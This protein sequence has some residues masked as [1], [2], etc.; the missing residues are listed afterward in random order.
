MRGPLTA[1]AGLTGKLTAHQRRAVSAGLMVAVAVL[2]WL[3]L[4][5]RDW[6]PLFPLGV[7]G[8]A[9]AL[10]GHRLRD[11]LWLGALCGV[12]HYVVALRW[13]TD[14]SPPGY[15]AVAV[16]ETVLLTAVAAVSPGRS[17]GRWP[18][19]WLVAPAAL[20]L[21]EAVQY[22]FPFGGFP[23]PALGLSLTDSPFLA[24]A[25]LGGA[26]FVT[27]LA[28][29][30]GG[31]L[32][33]MVVAGGKRG[34]RG[35]RGNRTR[36]VA[37]AT[38]VV[39][40]GLPLALSGAAMTR[41]AGSLDAVIVQG[42]GPRGLRAIFIDSMD[43]TNRHLEALEQV[44]GEPD[45]VLLPENVADVDGP[46][47]GTALDEAFAD[48]ARRLGTT[49]VVGVTE[50]E[51]D[52]FRNASVVWGPDGAITD[53]YEKQHRVPFG[54]Y[55]PLRGLFEA[56][57]DDTRFVPRDAIVGT[58]DAVVE[59]AGTPLAIVISYEVFFADRVADGVR[60]G[61]EVVL[62]PTN[63]SSYVGEEVPAIE[64]AASR[65]RAREFGRTVLQAAPTG[66]SAIVLPD[67]SVTRLSG[68]GTQ[69]L[70]EQ[71]VP[72]RTGLTPYARTGDWPVLVL[73]A[74]PLI[75]AAVA[76]VA[77]HVAAH[78]TGRRAVSSR[79]RE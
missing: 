22:R 45:V 15:A 67:G 52:G 13:M 44:D 16:L 18:G 53:R 63:A 49:L 33:G 37:A 68:L 74:L 3:A 10:A 36:L 1:A 62:A 54:E 21:L 14:F 71:S 20:V 8:F 61:G 76:R 48:E 24:V 47:A 29:L 7:A 66:Y 43:A 6:W 12:V 73:I 42:G 34:N 46:I 56:L 50:G 69:E 70:L 60:D 51:V 78:V 28:A 75:A 11:R 19:W 41:D 58:T 5:P 31:A 26:L 79:V 23:L 64:V 9:L 77:A 39:A 2:W 38:A 27:A 32:A 30:A 55:I 65:L 40:V 17:A 35:N 72:L 59:A 25:P 4:P 57:S